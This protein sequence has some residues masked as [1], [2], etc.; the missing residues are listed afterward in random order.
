MPDKLTPQMRLDY[1]AAAKRVAE[2]EREIAPAIS[3]IKVEAGLPAALE[4][5]EAIVDE[6]GEPFA[7]CEGCGAHIFDGDDYATDQDCE[8]YAC[9]ACKERWNADS[10][11]TEAAAEDA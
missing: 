7:T 10:A 11:A 6:V 9:G 1:A 4:A 5:L 8:V 3:S 2:I